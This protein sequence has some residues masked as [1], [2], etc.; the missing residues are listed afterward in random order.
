MDFLDNKKC[1]AGCFL[2]LREVKKIA[3][4]I[5][6]ALLLLNTGL[7]NAQTTILSETFT[8]ANNATSG[9]NWYLDMTGC[10]VS[11]SHYFK[12][13][14]NK[15]VA[16]DTDCDATFYTYAI[17][18]SQYTNVSLSVDLTEA[19]NL[20]GS[21]RIQVLYSLNGGTYQNFSTN[22]NLVDDF[23][24]AVASETGLSGDSVKI[25]IIASNNSS[26]D[27]YYVDNLLIRGTFKDTFSL[28]TIKTNGVC[29]VLGSIDLVVTRDSIGG[30][31]Y[32]WS[33]GATTQDLT[34]IEAGTYTVT[35]TNYHGR[36]MTTSATITDSSPVIGISGVK[37]VCPGGSTT[38][39]GTGGVSYVWSTGATTPSI[40]VTT[41]GT[42]TVTGTDAFGC[43]EPASAVVTSINNV[44]VA[45]Q[46][47]DEH[48]VNQCDGSIES[49]PQGGASPYAYVWSNSATTQNITNVCSG[50]YIVTVTD[51]QGCTATKTKLVN[52]A[53]GPIVALSA[54]NVYCLGDCGG[55]IDLTM[56]QGEEPFT[57]TWSDGPTTQ[58][59]TGLCIGSYCVTVSDVSG[60]T[61][62]ACMD[63]AEF[64]N[65]SVLFN[66]TEQDND[67]LG[68][69][70]STVYG[71]TPP[72]TYAWSN[73][74]TASSISNLQAGVYALTVTDSEGVIA[75]DVVVV[76]NANQVKTGSFI[77]NM[78]VVP[79]TIGNGLKPYGMVYDLVRNYNVPIKWIIN[80]NKSKDGTDFTYGGTAYKGGPFIVE[81]EYRSAAVDARIAYW[82]TQGVVGVTITSDIVV[83]VFQTITG[84][85]KLVVDQDNENLVIPYFT[86]AGIPSSIYTVG[87]PSDL[88]GCHD[89][90]VLPHADPTWTDHSFLRT[91]NT[92]NKGYI[93]S[94]CHAVSVLEGIANPGNSSQRMNFL[95]TNGLQCYRG[96]K[97]GPLIG[98]TH[99]D[100]TSPYTYDPA[101][102][103]D[104]IMQ[105]MGDLTPS[106][107]NGSEDWYIPLTTGGWNSNTAPAITT[108]D[109]SGNRKGVKLVYGPGFNNTDNGMVMY[110]AGH[111]SHGKGSVANQVA[112]QR[113]FFNFIIMASIDKGLHV[114]TNIPSTMV[115]GDTVELSA[116]ATTGSGPYTYAWTSNCAGTFSNASSANPTF[117][118]GDVP[119]QSKCVISVV[120]KDNCGRRTF[121]S[122]PVVFLNTLPARLS[123]S[124]DV[125]IATLPSCFGESD[126]S[127]TAVSS[128]GNSPYTYLWSNGATTAVV[129]NLSTGTYVVT[130]T[131]VNGC[132]AVDTHDLVQPAVI[133]SNSSIT[134]VSISG[135]SNG[136]VTMNPSGGTPLFT[137]LWSTGSTSQTISS[138]SVAMYY[139]TI[140]D[141]N[142]CTKVDSAFVNQ[143]CTCCIATGN[144]SN[145][146]TWN[147]ICS[148]GGG[149]YPGRLDDITIR[150]FQVTVDSTHTVK[151]LVL[152][153]SNS[154]V[155]RLSYTG[156]NSLNILEGLNLNTVSNGGNV[157]LEIDGSA[158]LRVNGDFTINHASGTDVTIKLNS[159]NGIDAKFWVIGNLN[160]TMSGGADD[161][162]IDT[163]GA[164][165]TIQV[166]GDIVFNNNRNTPSADM[167]L[168][169]TSTSKL[170]VGGDI[171]FN[172][173]RSQNMELLLSDYSTLKLAGSIFRNASPSKFGKITMSSTAKLILNGNEQQTLERNVGNTDNNTYTSL[174]VSNSSPSSPQVLLNGDVTVSNNI[175][176]D[177]G[178]IGTGSS[179]LILTSTLGGAING[180]SANSYVVGNLR[181][182]VVP[183]GQS[184]DFPLGYGSPNQYYWARIIPDNLIGPTY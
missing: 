4:P 88:N 29:G 132:L 157:E 72:Y 66:T 164:N 113:A 182:Y 3:T 28:A 68:S 117:I 60:C 37:N 70:S 85:A 81:A 10:S 167:I 53:S 168:T 98:E 51:N 176:F 177:D 42:F 110:E 101:Y 63:V 75:S 52:A 160:M 144:W 65:L 16:R 14:S 138:L 26:G 15:L 22:G 46:G 78:G 126:G 24:S 18:I 31:T 100:P 147:G 115:S 118:S 77:I 91:F 131:D 83:P 129:N 181:R 62:S 173:V 179:N 13:N 162:L 61:V 74:S 178:N 90:Y 6:F 137:Y 127:V 153:E 116:A 25:K 84:F 89:T 106:T 108:A 163:Y 166:N 107:E 175:T 159:N 142:S 148:G 99:G 130:S 33:N 30:Y 48:C 82:Q 54:T 92:V 56:L 172:G 32:I 103:S 8:A 94:G 180:H 17:D 165:D 139:V 97:C 39:T 86:N 134:N 23:T 76:N 124:T 111:T 119:P 34:G 140:T 122:Q 9:T 170:I 49:T 12:I 80:Q 55:A 121:V 171:D 149:K 135:G 143:P 93:W 59:R 20:S 69:I 67:I 161:L 41:A 47:F 19:G 155:T 5:L 64:S 125:V 146:A 112:A 87:L 36:T 151:S 169:M 145:P 96:G 184:Y 21:D 158:E 136:S 133:E 1:F 44:S 114:A 102:N 105:F 152:R 154:G 43:A 58:D 71:G 156:A 109:G 2:Y 128:G 183:T 40:A 123:V 45:L 50:Q 38:L 27:Y 73:F 11:G 7:T 120:V 35:V 104:P 95:T 174:T 141:A 150:G 79:Q 57:Y